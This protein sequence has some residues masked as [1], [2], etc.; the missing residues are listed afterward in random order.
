MKQLQENT[1]S[2]LPIFTVVGN[3]DVPQWYGAQGYRE[4]FRARNQ[5]LINTAVNCQGDLGVNQVCIFDNMV[6]WKLSE[7][8]LPRYY[9]LIY[10]KLVVDFIRSRNVRFR[11]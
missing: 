3:H 11:T 5:N 7:K 1:P 2:Q 8:Q 10:S 6:S 9:I 4:L